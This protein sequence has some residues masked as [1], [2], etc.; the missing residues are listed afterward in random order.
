MTSSCPVKSLILSSNKEITHFSSCS[1]GNMKIKFCQ[2]S[3]DCSILLVNI[4]YIFKCGNLSNLY[5]Y[6]DIGGT[7]VVVPAVSSDWIECRSTLC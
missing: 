4:S 5:M 7:V 2:W 1:V 3:P 6:F